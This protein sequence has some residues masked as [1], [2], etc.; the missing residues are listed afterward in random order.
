M[1]LH[2]YG[3]DGPTSHRYF[4]LDGVATEHRLLVAYPSGSRDRHRRRFWNATDGCC[5]FYKAPVDDM[6]Y[7]DAVLTDIASKHRIDS[8]RI[9]LLGLSNGGFM[10][11]RFACEHPGRVA[12]LVSLSGAGWRDAARCK[13]A[14][15]VA[16]LFIH[17]DA[18]EVVRYE[19]GSLASRV[20]DAPTPPADYPSARE[21]VAVWVKRG[22]CA[23]VPEVLPSL[24]LDA[25]V[26]GRETHVERW[27]G[28]QG[29]DIAL[30][31]LHG[32]THVPNPGPDFAA[33]IAGF[34]VVQRKP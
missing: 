14:E 13:P 22:G 3:E 4:G 24:D 31:T 27:R 25:N 18:D 17:G 21:S 28:C 9:Y 34:L 23:P 16:A 7:L 33:Q 30:W 19:G 29:G 32:S 5:N 20:T 11:N 8:K 15:S 6:A 1:V 26:L 10:A 2:G 12:A